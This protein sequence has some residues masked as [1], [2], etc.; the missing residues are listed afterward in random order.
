MYVNARQAIAGRGEPSVETSNL[1]IDEESYQ[2]Y[3]VPPGK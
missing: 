2:P 3:T 1:T